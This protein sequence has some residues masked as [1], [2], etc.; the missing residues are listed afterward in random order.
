MQD[1]KYGKLKVSIAS[2]SD[3]LGQESSSLLDRDRP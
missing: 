2:S 3:E 1:L